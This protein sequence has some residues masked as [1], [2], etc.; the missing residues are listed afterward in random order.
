MVRNRK[1]MRKGVSLKK[2]M[3]KMGPSLVT[4]MNHSKFNELLV[5]LACIVKINIEI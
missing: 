4:I 3:L 2:L 1:K 5:K